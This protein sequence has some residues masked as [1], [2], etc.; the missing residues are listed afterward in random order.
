MNIIDFFSNHL[1]NKNGIFFTKKNSDIS[2]PEQ[3]NEWYF[4]LEENSFWF[5]H[6]NNC[7]E[8]FINQYSENNLFF[9]IGGGNGYVSSFLQKN[10]IESILIEPGYNGCLNAQKRGLKN[11]VCS[12]IQDSGAKD[13]SIDSAGLFDVVEHI[14]NDIEFLK[15]IGQYIK[16]E[17]FLYITVPAYNFL[18][19]KEDDFAGH[20][21]RYTIKNISEKLTQSGFKIEYSTYIFFFLPLLVFL[22]R[23][24]PSKLGFYRNENSGELQQKDHDKSKSIFNKFILKLCNWELK[25]L[26]NK[27][28][29]LIGGS[30][31]I[32]AKKLK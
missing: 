14:E 11:I 9:D 22:F 1:E 23:T 3:G 10:N 16:D 31:L 6:R 7:I 2:Y 17:G 29:I 12:T 25:L 27:R 8:Y 18:W 32:V 21:R 24:I 28:K 20:Y 13:N 19:S 30:C 5:N 15:N 4:K 26:K